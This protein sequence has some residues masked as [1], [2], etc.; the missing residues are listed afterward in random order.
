VTQP[1]ESRELTE[2]IASSERKT[3]PV[4]ATAEQCTKAQELVNHLLQKAEE[5]GWI[6]FDM[7]EPV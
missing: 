7:S 4:I 1:L 5:S 2:N 6:D 3:G